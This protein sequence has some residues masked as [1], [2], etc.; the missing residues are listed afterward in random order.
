MPRCTPFS[1]AVS[2]AVA[3]GYSEID[4]RDDLSLIDVQRKIVVLAREI[5]GYYYTTTTLLHY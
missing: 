3:R 4:P 1:Q 2:V 5:I